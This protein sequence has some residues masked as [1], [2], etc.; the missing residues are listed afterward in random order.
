MSLFLQHGALWLALRTEGDL[1]RRAGGLAT[2]LWI[3]VLLLAVL[4]LAA[5]YGYTGLWNNYFNNPV[6]LV[7]PALAVVCL[8]LTRVKMGRQI[9]GRGLGLLRPAPSPWP[10]FSESSG[11]IPI[12]SL[13]ALSA[14]LMHERNSVFLGR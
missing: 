2:G 12:C 8:L 10:P 11:S 1:S 3:P 13:R 7:L 4:F 9:L 6:L 5:T 14:G